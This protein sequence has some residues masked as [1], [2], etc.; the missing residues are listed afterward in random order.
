MGVAIASRHLYDGDA[1]GAD[2]LGMARAARLAGHD[3]TLFA[4]H[5][6]VPDPV[7]PLAELAAVG[8]DDVVVYHH[9]VRADAGLRAVEGCRGRVVLRYHNVTPPRFFVG[10][11]ADAGRD[12]AAGRSQAARLARRAAAVWAASAFNARELAADV[13]DLRADE[14]PPFHQ[15]D[16]LATTQPDAAAVGSLDAWATTILCVGRAAPN[17]NLPLAVEAFGRY[18]ERFDRRSRLVLVGDHPYPACSAAVE[19]KVRSLGL[20]GCVTAAGR[21]TAG[22][23]AAVYRSA[24]ALLVTSE[25]EGFCVPLVEAMAVGVPAVA[26]PAAAVPDTGGDAVR[27]ADADPDALADAVNAVVADGAERER[28]VRAGRRRYAEHFAPAAIAR[29][30]LGL[31][32]ET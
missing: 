1:V 11:D 14:L 31:L 12:A 6:R 3:V 8:P 32:A 9:S 2:A 15:A 21:L 18:R 13:P 20:E 28:R 17:K 27:Y 16:A 22:Q 7:R 25:H 23:L 24:D 26:V 10:L 29:R 30:F 5:A 19:A 4:D